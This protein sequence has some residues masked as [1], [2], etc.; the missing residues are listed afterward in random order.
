M[1]VFSWGTPGSSISLL[2]TE[3]NALANNAGTV[4]GPEVDNTTNEYQQGRLQLNL[5]SS[6]LAFTSA[7]LVLIY[8]VPQE[9]GTYPLLTSGGTPVIAGPNY[10]AGAISIFPATLSSQALTEY[11]DNVAI[12]QNK[13]KP[14]LVSQADVTLPATGNTLLLFPTPSIVA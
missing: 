4:Y 5:A 14:V 11:L 6:S 3:L 13:W 10:F 7:S 2:T 9:G 1:A 8:F 12:P